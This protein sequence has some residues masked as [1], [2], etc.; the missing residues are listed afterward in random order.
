MPCASCP[1]SQSW[2]V[3]RKLFA[4]VPPHAM[5]P[6]ELPST[7]VFQTAMSRTLKATSQKNRPTLPVGVGPWRTVASAQAPL[8]IVRT[9]ARTQGVNAL[10]VIFVATYLADYGQATI[11]WG[12]WN[13]PR[14]GSKFRPHH[15]S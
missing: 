7:E 4:D 9:K 15:R 14:G 8:Q 10:T 3:V 13:R 11:Y 6:V 1:E 12:P 2:A 5:S